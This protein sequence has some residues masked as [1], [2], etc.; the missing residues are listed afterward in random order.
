M[1][2]GQRP[3]LCAVHA[4]QRDHYLIGGSGSNTFDL[5]GDVAGNTIV[6]GRDGSRGVQ[7]GKQ[8][9]VVTA[10]PAR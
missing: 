4:Q 3:H 8:P 1:R 10:Q 6:S 7:D 2:A 5:S 9:V